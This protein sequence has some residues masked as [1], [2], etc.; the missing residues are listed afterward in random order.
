MARHPKRPHSLDYIQRLFTDFTRSH[1]DRFSATIRPSW[2]AW[3]ISK[4]SPVMVIGQ[5]KGRDTKQKLHPQFRHA[6][7]RGLSQSDCG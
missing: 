5:Q 4:A 6:E 3:A 7:T 2:A 1:G